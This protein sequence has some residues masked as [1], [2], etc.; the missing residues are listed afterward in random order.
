MNEDRAVTTMVCVGGIFIVGGMMGGNKLISPRLYTIF[1]DK[2][3][4]PLNPGRYRSVQKQQMS[5]LPGNP[6]FVIVGQ[7]G[8]RY[9]VPEADVAMHELYRRVTKPMEGK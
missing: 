1:D 6:P 5:P 2:E 3:P 7:D 9:A 8:F 4:D